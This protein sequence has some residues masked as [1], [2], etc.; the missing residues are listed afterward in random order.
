MEHLTAFDPLLTVQ[1]LAARE[2]LSERSLRYLI[3]RH[4]VPTYRVG[5]VRIRRS[6]WLEWLAARRR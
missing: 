3:V 2:G 1:Q 5:G 4:G 6:E